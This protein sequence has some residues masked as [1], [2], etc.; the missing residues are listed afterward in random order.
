MKKLSDSSSTNLTTR[1]IDAVDRTHARIAMR[2][3]DIRNDVLDSVKHGIDRAET[4]TTNLFKRARTGVDRV[5][6][7][8]ADAVNRAQG[9]VGQA[10]ERARLARATPAEVVVV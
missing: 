3:H 5:D 7:V 2:L 10:I 1:A 6:H 9:A 8:S 4:I